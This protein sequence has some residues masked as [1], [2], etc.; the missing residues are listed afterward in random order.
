MSVLNLAGCAGER[1]LGVGLGGLG[2]H[3]AI[4]LPGVMGGRI[5][6]VAGERA[7]GIPQP[8]DKLSIHAN[9]W[10]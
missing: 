9:F 5:W 10:R 8:Q 2:P 4:N 7:G 3:A 1:N 6:G